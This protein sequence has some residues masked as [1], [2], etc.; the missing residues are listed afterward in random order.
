MTL[1]AGGSVEVKSEGTGMGS[2]FTLRLPVA[3][4][5]DTPAEDQSPTKSERM[6]GR[7]LVPGRRILV[8]IISDETLGLRLEDAQRPVLRLMR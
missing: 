8:V 5:C 6:H 1:G 4:P 2:E 7:D 3:S